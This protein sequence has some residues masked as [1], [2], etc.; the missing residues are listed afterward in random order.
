MSLVSQ[1]DSLSEIEQFA[2]QF[3]QDFGLLKIDPNEMA[4]DFFRTLNDKQK[5]SL[6]KSLQ[7]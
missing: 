2:G 3:H 1:D 7:Q 6:H 5:S 4:H